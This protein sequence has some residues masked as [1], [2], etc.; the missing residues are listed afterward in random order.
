MSSP[1]AGLRFQTSPRNQQ[2][3][4]HC[5]TP[6]DGA[7]N[8]A[9]CLL[10]I[11][12]PSFVRGSIGGSASLR[13]RRQGWPAIASGRHTLIA[14]PT[15]SGKT[16]AAFLTAIDDLVRQALSPEG[17][18]DGTQ[19]LYV[20]PLKALANDIKANLIDPL[21]EIT[22]LA[23]EMGTPIGTICSNPSTGVNVRTR[24]TY[25]SQRP[26]LCSFC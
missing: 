4:P 13:R 16:L 8:L 17:L 20:S 19:V 11:C 12:I 23:E 9:S 24:R 7:D 14:A 15:G 10:S 26:R 18:V 6:I 25:S 5:Q 2:H 22:M 3:A 1:N 21:N